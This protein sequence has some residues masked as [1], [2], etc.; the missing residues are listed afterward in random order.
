MHMTYDPSVD[1]EEIWRRIGLEKLRRSLAEVKDLVRGFEQGLTSL[2]SCNQCARREMMK[3][4]EATGNRLSGE[5]I[6]L[7]VLASSLE[8]ALK[9]AEQTQKELCKNAPAPCQCPE[10]ECTCHE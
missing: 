5:V 3:Q 2:P 8:K 4:I 7:S 6:S 9:T 1:T 10:G